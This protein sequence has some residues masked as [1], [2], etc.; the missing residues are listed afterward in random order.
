[1]N[2]NIFLHTG[3]FQKK[4]F[5]R[6]FFKSSGFNMNALPTMEIQSKSVNFFFFK[7]YQRVHLRLPHELKRLESLI[8]IRTLILIQLHTLYWSDIKIR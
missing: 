6:Q 1:M 7:S 3:K 8:F 4:S 5:F 2:L